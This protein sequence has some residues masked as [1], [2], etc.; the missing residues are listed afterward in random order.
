MNDIPKRQSYKR[1]LLRYVAPSLMCITRTP[2]LTLLLTEQFL[3]SNSNIPDRFCNGLNIISIPN[4]N[5]NNNNTIQDRRRKLLRK[6]RSN[7]NSN[8]ISNNNNCNNRRLFSDPYNID[9]PIQQSNTTSRRNLE[10][11][12]TMMTSSCQANVNGFYGQPNGRFYESM[13]LYQ[14]TVVTGTPFAEII[15]VISPALNLDI[16]NLA[17]PFLFPQQCSNNN[18]IATTTAIARSS[19]N[20]DYEKDSG[21][22]ESKRTI[23]NNKQRLSLRHRNQQI[24]DEATTSQNFAIN[25]I[26]SLPTDQFIMSGCKFTFF[27]RNFL[28]HVRARERYCVSLTKLIIFHFRFLKMSLISECKKYFYDNNYSTMYWNN[29]RRGLLRR[30]RIYN[31]FVSRIY[32]DTT[33]VINCNTNYPICCS[34]GWYNRY[35]PKCY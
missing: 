7:N 33:D 21:T 6:R 23:R 16:V 27:Y 18:T 14:T 8:N 3:S 11:E 4:N 13:F 5:N 31:I 30:T 2:T 12:E 17:I 28:P 35:N 10:Q 34:N 26:S 24:L 19:S 25:A 20:N 9:N 29:N 22:A 15:T 1:V 32:N